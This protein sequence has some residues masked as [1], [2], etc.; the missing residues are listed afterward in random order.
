NM[1]YRREAFEQAGGFLSDVNP[2]ADTP[3]GGEDIDLAWRGKRNGWQNRFAA[4]ANV[5]HEE[6]RMP[7][8]RWGFSKRLFIFPLL[9]KKFPEVRAMAFAGI[10]FDRI[11]ACLV[12]ALGGTALTAWT[13]WMLLF[14]APYVASRA[15]QSSQTLR[16][17]MRLA[18]V[19]VYFPRDLTS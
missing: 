18:R 17:P 15:L 14:C 16:G 12:I 9:L 1:L 8:W 4:D 10:F 3:M 2:P 5:Y 6:V 7:H 13:P 11:Q 19:L